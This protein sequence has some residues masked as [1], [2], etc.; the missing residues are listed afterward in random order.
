MHVKVHWEWLEDEAA[1]SWDAKHCLF[2]FADPENDEI[3]YLSTAGTTTVRACC[4]ASELEELWSDLRGI[5]IEQVSVLV[6]KPEVPD[7]GASAGA[8]AA[9]AAAALLVA[10]LQ[11]S[12]N[13]DD[14]RTESTAGLEVECAGDWPYEETR[15]IAT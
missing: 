14:A 11:P 4:E 2:A 6:G 13:L 15:F 7:S 5:G 10:E 8:F 3:V 1:P 9:T 12:G